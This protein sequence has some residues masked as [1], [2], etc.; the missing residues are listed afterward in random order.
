MSGNQG[1]KLGRDNLKQLFL[2]ATAQTHFSFQG[3]CYDQVDGVAMGSP[4]APFLANLYTGHHEKIWLQQYEGPSI[5]LYRRYV[6]D[7][8]CLFNNNQDAV[9]FFNISTVRFTMEREVNHKLP[10]LDVLNR[11][12]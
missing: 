3:I 1:G 6:D 2:F 10:F 7:T 11:Q 8:F 12:Q 9:A 5:Y 4:L